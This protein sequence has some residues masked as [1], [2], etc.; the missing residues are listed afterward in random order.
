MA[1][2]AQ[3]EN[4]LRKADSAGDTESATILAREIRKVRTTAPQESKSLVDQIQGG[5][6]EY[7]PP[8]Q[9]REPDIAEKIA[10]NPLTRFAMAASAP[11]RA[12]F[13][14]MPEALGGKYWQEQNQRISDM[15]KE[16]TKAYPGYVNTTGVASDIA[17]SVMSPA[18]L[19]VMKAMPSAT[20]LGQGIGGGTLFGMMQPTGKT[21]NFAE[22]K[23]KQAGIGA[24]IGGVIPAAYG[25]TKYLG[26]AGRDIADLVL[27]KGA[28]RISTRHQANIIGRDNLEKVSNA[29]R[30]APEYVQGSKPTAAQAVAHMPEG[31]PVIAQQE[32][33]SK[34]PGGVSALFGQRKLDQAASREVAHEVLNK[35]TAPMREAAL[36]NAGVVQTKSIID[37]I[38][39]IAT[40]PEFEKIGLV[41]KTMENLRGK[42]TD[43]EISAN[44]LY[45]I[46]K[47]IGNTIKA[48]AVET[49]NWDKRLSSKLEREIQLAIDD[50]I[51]NAGGAGWKDYL[52]K[53]SAGM[54]LIEA[55]ISR[56]K[57]ALKP[58]QKTNLGGGINVAEETRT[59]LPNMLSRP[60]MLA[61]AVMK[62]L[63]GKKG[64]IEPRVDAYMA[65]Q[66][67]NP[68]LLAGDLT[69]HQQISRVNEI[70]DEIVKRS[71]PAAIS[72]TQQ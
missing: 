33:T 5:V 15:T 40:K 30:N 39:E 62:T 28:E 21:D 35:A 27:P 67:L 22:E 37:K 23:L 72:A 2:L 12:G 49:K 29:L 63:A 3:L 19:K 45:N 42:L 55:D 41:E 31:S 65:Q 10:A 7:K 9:E 11:F 16:G 24:A 32:I 51:E 48:N 14:M 57:Q 66:Q 38:D 4:A 1:D 54:K 52:A 50:A 60:M 13:E 46:R 17:G 68:Q 20:S 26:G 36:Q 58:V 47:E 69:K 44:G 61:N 8:V 34:T 53:Y 6:S 25:I 43:P 59:H 64:G 18:A 56:A 71:N 70:I